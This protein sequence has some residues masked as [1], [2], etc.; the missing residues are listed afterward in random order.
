MAERALAT[1]FVNIVPGTK[2]LELWMKKGLPDAADEAGKTSSSRLGGG[3]LGGLKSALG[4]LAVAFSAVGIASFTGDMIRSAEEGAKVDATLSNITKQM[5]IFGGATGTVV[6]RLQDFATEQMKMTGI[7]DDVIKAGQAKLMTFSNVAKSAGTMGGAFDKATTLAMDL[8]AAGFGSVDSASVM[9]G[10]ALQDPLKGITAL[11]RVGV[12]LSEDQKKQVKDFMAVNDVASAQKVILG[13]VERQVGGTA[14]ASAT[15]LAKMKAQWDDLT[16]AIGTELQPVISGIATFITT[17]VIPAM[18]GLG[19]GIKGAFQWFSDNQAWILPVLG[20][21]GTALL[22]IAIYMGV[23]NVVAAITAAGGMAAIIASTW[24]WTVA[25]LANPIT[26]IILGIAA[27][28]AAIIF[29]A[30]NWDAVVKWIGEAW[31]NISKFF[32]DGFNAVMKWWNDLWTGVWEFVV[33]VWNRITKWFGDAL[34]WL[35]Q[36]FLDWTIYGIIIKNWDAIVKFFGDAWN[37]IIKFFTDAGM[38]IWN[39]IVSTFTNVKNFIRDTFVNV[40]NVVKAPINGLIGLINGMID[41]LNA[42][43]VD[44]P[45][46]VPLVGGKKFGFSIPHIPALAKGGFVDKPTTALIGEAGPEVVTPL[47]DFERMMGMG[48]GSGQT[49]N[50]YAAPNTSLDSEQALTQALKRAKVIAAW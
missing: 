27:L 7:D 25:L 8:S 34:G 33:G 40:L 4:P 12:S 2:D 16:Q 23:L 50:Y 38:N 32:A 48:N 22:G 37:G 42:I 19:A 5:N 45:D 35:V 17:N 11:Q 21:I 43:H 39:G 31:A 28:V 24:A 1:A 3:M 47:K 46:W 20:A 6:T 26:W 18:S 29:L 49:V 30:M 44:I 15:P 41:G 36:M 14:A 9:L 13:E 10:K